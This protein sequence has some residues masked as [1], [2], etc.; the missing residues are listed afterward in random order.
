MER[1]EWNVVKILSCARHDWLNRLQ[2]IKG[3]IALNRLDRV[4]E[5][6]EEII[7]EAGHESKLTN[8]R[9]TSFAEYMMT[10]NWRGTPIH[11]EIEV[12]GDAKNLS[13]YDAVLTKW[14]MGFMQLLEANADGMSTHHVSVS[15]LIEDESVR[16]FF[17]FSGILTNIQSIQDWLEEERE[18]QPLKIIEKHIAKEELS[19][20]VELV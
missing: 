8:T 15:L 13:S 5:I 11:L 18:K 1:E 10:Y 4:N 14:T 9:L 3:N 19:V 6:I 12:L 17:D 2:L 20:V 7:R 16:F